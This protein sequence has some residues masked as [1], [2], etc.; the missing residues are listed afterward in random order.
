MIA[1]PAPQIILAS[2]SESRKAVFKRLNLP[3]SCISPDIDE[4]HYMQE[5]ASEYVRRLSQEKALV[6][7]ENNSEAIVIG[8]DQCA[9]L[10]NE[11]LGKPGSH[12]NALEQLKNAQGR[13]V[14]FHTGLCV[15]YQPWASVDV[16]DILFE[17]DFRD[18]SDQQLERYLRVEQPYQCAGSFKSEGYGISLFQRLR[19]DD[20]TALI[21]L[22]LIR[23][24]QML[25]KLGV[26][27]V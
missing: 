24:V 25:E 7:A 12:A 17:V 3:F 18:L 21:G 5:S 15:I 2:S 19:G 4:S 11:I 20:P 13:T 1:S 9:V 8:S 22:P 26:E 14:V 10:D 23:L 16:D 6:V 27:V